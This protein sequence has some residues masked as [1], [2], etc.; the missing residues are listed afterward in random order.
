MAQQKKISNSF[1]IGIFVLLGLV[2]LV[3]FL[4]WMGATNFLK[5]YSYYVTYFEE[6]VGG[7]E[8]GSSVK[9]LGV[10]CGFVDEVHIAPD[11]RLVEIVLKLDKN[12]S[13]DESLVAKLEMAGLAGGKYIQLTSTEKNKPRVFNLNFNPPHQV[14]N[15]APSQLDE[16]AQS[17]ESIISQLSKFKWQE[18]SNSLAGTLEGTN[19]LINN[20][21]IASLVSDLKSITQSINVLVAQLSQTSI[22][23]NLEATSVSINKAAKTL[24]NF[25]VKLDSKIDSVNI[26]YYFDMIY[27]DF[28]RTFGN[29][30]NAIDAISTKLQSSVLGINIL[31]EDIGKTNRNL[32]RVLRHINESP[33]IFLTEPP[34]P[35][36]DVK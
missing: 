10:S 24:E 27:G 9:Y 20:L 34:P 15:S 16:M 3:G 4:V 6:S 22:P 2:L 13:V 8:N 17:A 7:L 26:P 14:I 32:N 31:L 12:L 30:N 11:G 35:D 21:D 36:D 28:N 19:K 29:A 25:S 1:F 18:I 33:Y 23:Q 5:D